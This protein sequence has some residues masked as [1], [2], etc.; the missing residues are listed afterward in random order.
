MRIAILT[1]SRADYGIYKP[2]LKALGQDDAIEVTII[3]LGTHLSSYHG[4]TV[5]DIIKDGFRVNYRIPSLLLTDDQQSIA[6]SM[7][8]TTI[9]FAEFWKEHAASFDW[10]F[11]LGDRFEM[12]SAV[13]AGVPFGIRFA[14]IHGGETTLGAIDNVF[15]HSMSLAAQLHFVATELFAEKVKALTE[16]A[17]DDIIVTGALSLDNLDTISYLDEGTVYERWRVDI[18]S[19]YVLI[20][21][22]PETVSTALISRH[23]EVIKEVLTDLQERYKLVI[24]M[25]NADTNG[26]KFRK[27]FQH[28]GRHF[29]DNIIL[30][31][32]FGIQGYFTCM[33]HARFLLGNTSSGIIEAAS[34]DRYVVNVGDR[35]K[36]RLSGDNVLHV[37]FDKE[38]ILSAVDTIE[39]SAGET[40]INPYFHG[41]AAK[42]IIETLKARVR[43]KENIIH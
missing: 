24:T 38:Q 2:L 13:M 41:G 31:E 21:V 1:S 42:T 12:F 36:G 6:T 40:M 30:V 11:C 29:P 10:V 43:T 22:H 5:N 15:R 16:A 14:H 25:P 27:V 26:S 9:K 34:F 19:D 20:T 32:N 28:L 39:R 18:R 3:A 17:A 4:D 7:G 37:P 35:Q 23:L 8:L 33:K